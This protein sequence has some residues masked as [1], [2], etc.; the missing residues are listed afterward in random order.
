VVLWHRIGVLALGES[1][2]IV[3]VSAPHRAEAFEAARFGIDALKA[4]IPIWKQ[5]TWADDA[6]DPGEPGA[7]RSGWALG[8][9]A[10]RDPADVGASTGQRQT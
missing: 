6:A 7:S 8:A 5:E 1:S 9:Q 4:T 2:V 3:A 10:V